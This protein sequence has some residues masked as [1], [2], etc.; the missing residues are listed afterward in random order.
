M[1]ATTH[2]TYKDN[3]TQLLEQSKDEVIEN[4][5]YKMING[6]CVKNIKI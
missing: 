1:C 5:Y 6:D 2:K 3:K 4:E